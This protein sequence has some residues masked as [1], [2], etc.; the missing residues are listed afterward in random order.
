MNYTYNSVGTNTVRLIV[1]GPLGVSTNSRVNYILVTNIPPQQVVSPATNNYGLVA[2]SQSSTQNFSVVNAGVDSLTGTATVIS[3]PYAIVS[4]SPYNVSGGK[5]GTVSVAFNPVT[6]GSFTNSVV[7]AS[8]GGNSTN[9]LIGSGAISPSAAFTGTPTNGLV[10]LAV[11]FTDTSTGTI[12]NRSWS[13]GDGG[14]TNTLNTTVAHTYNL[15]GTNTVILVVTGPLGVSTN[16]RINYILVTNIPPQQVV[17]P[18]SLGFGLLPVGQS[19]TQAFSVANNGLQTLIGTA[20]V[21]GTTFTLISGSPF[22]VGGGQTGM[23]NVSFSPVAAGAFTGSVVFTS[24]GGLSTNVMTG[25]AA[26]PA[27]R[28]LPP[29]RRRTVSHRWR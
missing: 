5:T 22:T 3:G 27:S 1:T 16:T 9:T 28:W 8:N 26:V 2:V 19:S 23:V 20:T 17:S 15:V 4:G 29:G 14:T 12:T 10:P 6:V 24:N 21:S 18:G 11:T 7:F 13:F 25:A